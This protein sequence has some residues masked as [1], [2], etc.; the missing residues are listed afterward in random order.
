MKNLYSLIFSSILTVL[1]MAALAAAVNINKA[2]E[3]E[4]A[5]IKGIGPQRAKAIVEFREQHGQFKSVDD[6]TLVKGIG[7]AIVSSNRD[8]LTTDQ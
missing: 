6:L 3:V 7:P 1:P 8:R 4:L 5:S 2:D